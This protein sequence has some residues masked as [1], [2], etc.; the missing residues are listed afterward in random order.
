MPRPKKKGPPSGTTRPLKPID[1]EMVDDLLISGCLG[2][3]I[4]P[5]FDMHP[6]TFYDRVLIEK[7]VGFTEYSSKKKAHGEAILRDVQFKKAIGLSD[8]GDNTL[9]I[10]LG[11]NR[12]NQRET[13]V[14]EV[15]P[16]TVKAFDALMSQTAQMQET[17][18]KERSSKSTEIDEEDCEN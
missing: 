16:E 9:L 3:E 17:L 7:G 6:E 8:K 12:L 14:V 18:G 5:F 2:T 4:A 1:W 13:A 11:K 15:A 10:W